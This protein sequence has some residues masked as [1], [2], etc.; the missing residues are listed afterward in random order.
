METEI[1]KKQIL[2]RL[3]NSYLSTASDEVSNVEGSFTFDTL[4]ANAVEFEKTYAELNLVLEASFPQ[5]SWGEYLTAKAEEH[6]VI[7]KPETNAVVTLTLTGKAN[8]VV[9][10]G[11]LFSTMNGINFL[12]LA[13]ITIKGDGTASVKAQAMD[14]G[15]AG[16]VKAGTILKIPVTIYGVTSVTN[17]ADAYDGFERETDQE[18]LKRL[19]FKVREPATSGNVYHYKL[20]ASSVPGVGAVKILPLWNGNGT[21]KVL[22]LDTNKNAASEDLI[23]KVKAEI[24]DNA[25]IGATVTVSAPDLLTVDISLKVTSG[26]GKESGIKDAVNNYFKERLFNADAI[27]YAQIGRIILDNPELTG[28]YDYNELTINGQTINVSIKGT[29]LPVVGTVTLK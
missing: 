22:V 4:A 8:T 25:P 6:G 19:L 9:P 20:W 5:T 12:T 23:N 10:K 24:D 14:S 2:D 17:K 1:S 18:L 16:N 11:S 3:I 28:V 29:Q 27:S 21:V 13:D 15:S 26:D 7:R